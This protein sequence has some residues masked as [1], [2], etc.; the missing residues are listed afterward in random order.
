MFFF[1]FFLL[2]ESF[3]LVLCEGVTVRLLRGVAVVHVVLVEGAAI[4]VPG[5]VFSDLFPGKSL[6]DLV[7]V[8]GVAG[9][10]PEEGVRG[11]VP[12]E[13]VPGLVLSEVVPGLMLGEVIAGLMPGE[14]AAGL[15][16]GEVPEEG[17]AGLVVGSTLTAHS[18]GS[19]GGP[20]VDGRR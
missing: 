10:V 1:D 2:E 7:P 17:T 6:E 8:E 3:G 18:R 14:A 11:L 4:R 16:P 5:E 20:R 19:V 9:L 12:A 13:G 15:A